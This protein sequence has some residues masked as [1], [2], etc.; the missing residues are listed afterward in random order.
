MRISDKTRR[1]IRR[2]VLFLL[3]I[4]A[5]LVTAGWAERERNAEK[6]AV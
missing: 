3:G 1:R 4:V 2:T 5:V 6:Y